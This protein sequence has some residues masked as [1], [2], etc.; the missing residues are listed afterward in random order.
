MKRRTFFK[1]AALSGSALAVTGF[2][3][4]QSPAQKN[5]QFCPDLLI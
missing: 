2:A 4:C 3:V 5:L 1:T